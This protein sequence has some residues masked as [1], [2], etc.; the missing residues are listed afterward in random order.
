MPGV[1]APASRALAFGDAEQAACPSKAATG[2]AG[3]GKIH[4][5]RRFEKPIFLVGICL[6]KLHCQP[7]R[8]TSTGA[9]GHLRMAFHHAHSMTNF[10][11]KQ[12]NMAGRNHRSSSPSP[13]ARFA[14]GSK[15]GKRLDA[16]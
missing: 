9:R 10:Q 12:E 6:A 3:M 4:K 11:S 5:L 2:G 1:V 8:K 13:Q 7:P 15:A 14:W 16:Y